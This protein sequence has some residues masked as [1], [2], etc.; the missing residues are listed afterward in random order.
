MITE[1]ATIRIRPETASVWPGAFVA[2]SSIFARARGCHKA[3][4]LSCVEDPSRY[5]IKVSWDT[6][7]DHTVAFEADGLLHEFIA[8]V[9]QYF[10]GEPEVLHYSDASPEIP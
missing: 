5:I 9:A 1:I 10:D 7:E 8:A 6:V 2:T 3:Q 4:L